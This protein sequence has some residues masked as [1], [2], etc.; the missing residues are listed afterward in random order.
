MKASRL[1]PL[2]VLSAVGSGLAATIYVENFEGG[3]AGWT[4]RDPGNM[5]VTPQAAVGSPASG[6][7]QGSFGASFISQTDAFMIDSGTAFLGTYAGL[8]G[9][10]FDLYAEDVTPSDAAV[11]LVSG[12]DTFFFSL[13]LSGMST[14]VW[15]PFT[16]SLTYSAGWV[17]GQAAFN[18]ML[19]VAGVDQ[20]EVQL[21]TSGTGAQLYY[22][23]N[24][25]TTS[26]DLGG[27]GGPSAIPEPSTLSNLLL[28]AGLFLA[29][30]RG[31]LAHV[32]ARA[33]GSV[34]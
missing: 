5:T 4:D 30:R 10:T 33:G 3:A 27:G 13:D 16:V 11:R 17:G 23:D 9:F 28:V 14:D 22:L 15:T 29:C 32:R 7:L 19:N 12:G 24:F 26:D 6:A 20:V 1:I 21:T 18:N 2:L 8:T 31:V 34:L 25:G